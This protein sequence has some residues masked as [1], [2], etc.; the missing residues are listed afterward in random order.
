[1]YTSWLLDCPVSTAGKCVPLLSCQKRAESRFEPINSTLDLTLRQMVFAFLT[2]I[3]ID[4]VIP[5]PDPS[6]VILGL[7]GSAKQVAEGVN[8]YNSRKAILYE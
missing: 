2:P 8:R 7:L 4:L 1:M 3:V 5:E 6:L